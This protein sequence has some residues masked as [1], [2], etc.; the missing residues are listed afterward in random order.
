MNV[1]GNGT[2]SACANDHVRVMPVEVGVGDTDGFGEVLVRESRFR[3]AW[4]PLDEGKDGFTPPGFEV[5]PTLEAK[6]R[7]FQPLIWPK[8]MGRGS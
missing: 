3:T 7:K 5:Q 8:L 6:S 2:A 4:L 1:H